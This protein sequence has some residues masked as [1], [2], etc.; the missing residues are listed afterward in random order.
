MHTVFYHL[1]SN[2]SKAIQFIPTLI[3]IQ[4]LQNQKISSFLA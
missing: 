3:S 4:Y 1:E 2:D